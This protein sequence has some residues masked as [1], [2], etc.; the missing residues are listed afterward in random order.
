MANQRSMTMGEPLKSKPTFKRRMIR[1]LLSV[2]V[3][4]S[5]GVLLLMV[6]Q[7]RLI[8]FPTGMNPEVAAQI[9]AKDGFVEW[10]NSAGQIIG[11]HWPARSSSKGA[12]LVVHGNAGCAIDR[13]YLAKPI[14]EAADVDVFVLEYPGYGVRD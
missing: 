4:Y 1:T 13:E 7:R 9:A 12:V 14:R 5:I 3:I 10:R 8:Y 6:F 11:W 2:A